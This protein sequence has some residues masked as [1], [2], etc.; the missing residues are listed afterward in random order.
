MKNS[1]SGERIFFKRAAVLEKGEV[2][3]RRSFLGSVGAGAASLSE[4][5]SV[6]AL[7]AENAVAQ[8]ATSLLTP[9]EI[10][11]D[12][13]FWYEVQQSFSVSRNVIGL[14]NAAVN[15]SPRVV[16]EAVAQHIWEQ[17]RVP[18]LI[19]STTEPRLE[20]VRVGL[21]EM[22][23][24]DPEELAIVQN[25]TQALHTV[26]LGLPLKPG[27]EVVTTTQ[28]Y[29][30][31]LDGL[32]QRQARD[33]IIVKKIKIPMP[34]ETMDE[35]AHAYER[36]LTPRTKLILVSHMIY[37]TGQIVPVK[38]ICEMA[39][40]RGIEVVVDG[41]Q[42]F[43][44]LDFKVSDLG[45]DYFGTSLHKWLMAPK[46]T[47]MLY[48]KRDKI[49]KL[50]P[51]W[52]APE[53]M[54]ENIRKFQMLGT[55]SSQHLAIAEALAFHNG[56]GSQRKEARLRY[57]TS[58]W[59]DKIKPL[60]NIRFHS[61][62]KPGMGCALATVEVMGVN[63]GDLTDYLMKRHQIQVYNVARRTSEFQG[64][65]ISPCLQTT[66]PELDRFCAV[67]EQIAKNGLPKSA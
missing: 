39:H 42:T 14:H 19:F 67:M 64:I 56:I 12:E 25:T 11:R 36:A 33:G 62:F 63:S 13:S 35:L 40:K 15:P 8:R 22:F 16:T 18:P 50:W 51:L 43:G 48:V 58:Y 30:A 27:D 41:A 21:A 20:P 1:S 32:E 24:C 10:A 7:H 5:M 37:L 44:Q 4:L 28:E 9:D 60:P 38:R 59:V 54:K 6:S 52:P 45:C 47:G 46:V 55:Q 31:M 57:L 29:W 61:S 53:R 65:R 66:L 23:G 2:V 49:A 26:F 3:N 34:T 17:E